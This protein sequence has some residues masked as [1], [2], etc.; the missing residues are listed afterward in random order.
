MYIYLYLPIFSPIYK[1]IQER[2]LRKKESRDI[3][4]NI[5]VTTRVKEL[6]VED[7][8]EKNVQ[9]LE[10][11][12]LVKK[13]KVGTPEMA[14]KREMFSYYFWDRNTRQQPLWYTI[15]GLKSKN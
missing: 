10:P 14:N 3:T 12:V 9:L 6:V 1:N 11:V 4:V 13:P 8:P 15:L 2:W 5:V 7:I